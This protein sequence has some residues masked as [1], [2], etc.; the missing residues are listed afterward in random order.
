MRLVK[1]AQIAV[2]FAAT[3]GVAL[4]LSGSAFA[5]DAPNGDSSVQPPTPQTISSQARGGEMPVVASPLALPENGDRDEP[6]V[7]TLGPTSEVSQANSSWQ[8][9][10]GS[11]DNGNAGAGLSQN[12]SGSKP[13]DGLSKA[14]PAKGP[15]DGPALSD[16]AAELSAGSP[17]APSLSAASEVLPAQPVVDAAPLLTAGMDSAKGVEAG[18]V[19]HSTV[20]PI[21]PVITSH[22]LP[23]DLAT[24]VPSAPVKAKAPSLPKSNGAFGHLIAVLAGTIVPQL[25]LPNF[26]PVGAA[27]DILS[28]LVLSLVAA[29]VFVFS[30]GLWLRRGGF[31]T[32]AR[33]DSSVGSRLSFIATP[34]LLGYVLAEPRLHGPFSMVAETKFKNL[35]SRHSQKGGFIMKFKRLIG[36]ASGACGLSLMFVGGAMASDVTVGSTGAG[37]TQ[38]VTIENQTTTSTDNTNVVNV[39][40]QNVQLPASGDVQADNNTS[41]GGLSS[42]SAMNESSATTVVTVGDQTAGGQGAST[43]AN[44]SVAPG[45]GGG[46]GAVGVAA[47]PFGRGSVLGAATTGG[48]GAGAAMLPV[49]GPQGSVDVSALR[50]AW[51]PQTDAPTAG[52]AKTGRSVSPWLLA[53][54][55]AI[56]LTGALGTLMLAR[57]REGRVQI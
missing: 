42:G 38:N 22:A 32:A 28:L 37:S 17:D 47:G 36:A 44:P 9:A 29:G 15:T 24:G 45:G 3:S 25:F 39:T 54:A 30:Y 34:N 12:D 56:G 14:Q 11:S 31:A 41:A 57:R 51:R 48:S 43:G 2:G 10:R 50:A 6:P 1:F 4:V 16:T 13:P 52:L 35:V 49:T 23:E 20:L 33:G 18:V 7:S 55:S 19:F 8:T 40:S 21:Q 26:A 46:N 27:T 53:M 5:A